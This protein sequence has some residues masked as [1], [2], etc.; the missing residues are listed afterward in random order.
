MSLEF[1]VPQ[2]SPIQFYAY[3]SITD[4]NTYFTAR[5]GADLWEDSS[6]DDKSQALVHATRLIDRLNFEGVKYADDQP[7]E[8]PRRYS[9][10]FSW[11]FGGDPTTTPIPT[12]T[13]NVPNEIMFACCEIALALLDGVDPEQEMNNL[14]SVSQGYGQVRETYDRTI[15]SEHF[16]AGIPS[17]VAWTYLKPFLHDPAQISFVRV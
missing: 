17:A 13:P 7:L 6:D 3:I 9:E 5:V 14:T 2:S 12:T 10:N 8:F 16:R 4:A 1:T 11:N 15:R